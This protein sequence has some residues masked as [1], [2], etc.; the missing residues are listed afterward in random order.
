[1]SQAE[2]GRLSSSELDAI[3]H[4]PSRD[5]DLRLEAWEYLRYRRDLAER[6]DWEIAN[7]SQS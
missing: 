4:D 7:R 5:P 1:M 6:L 3:V 2:L